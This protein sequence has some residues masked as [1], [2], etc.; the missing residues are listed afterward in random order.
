MR[1]DLVEGDHRFWLSVG[2]AAVHIANKALLL[3]SEITADNWWC[4]AW[5]FQENYHGGTRMQL[6]IHHDQSLEPQKQRYPI[7]GEIPCELYIPSV[8]FSTQVTRLCLALC[9]VTGLTP[10]DLQQID[11][12]LRAARRYTLILDGSTSIITTVIADIEA[13]GLLNL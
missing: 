9:R 7:V 10:L 11:Y 1:Q 2:T 6:L 4:R 5:T 3:L 12:V 8:T 13:R